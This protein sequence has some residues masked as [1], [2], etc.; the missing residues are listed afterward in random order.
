MDICRMNCTGIV[1]NE[2]CT[3]NRRNGFALLIKIIRMLSRSLWM[4]FDH[5]FMYYNNQIEPERWSPI[6]PVCLHC[7]YFYICYTE[8]ITLINLESYLT[9]VFYPACF[10]KTLNDGF[11]THIVIHFYVHL[12]KFVLL[13]ISYKK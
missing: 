4:S 2:K 1:A 5:N 11:C 7:L 9:Q 13:S 10:E 12:P 3:W 6:R 8:I